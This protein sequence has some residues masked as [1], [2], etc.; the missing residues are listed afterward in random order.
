M[1]PYSLAI[2]TLGN[3][4][5]GNVENNNVQ[6][7]KPGFWGEY[8]GGETPANAGN[9]VPDNT[10]FVAPL[11]ITIDYLGSIYISDNF[12]STITKIGPS[13]IVTTL[14]GGGNAGQNG[15]G[16]AAGFN[17]P[18]GLGTDLEG[19]VYVADFDDEEIRKISSS[20]SGNNFSRQQF[21]RSYNGTGT[22]PLLMGLWV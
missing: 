21:H 14:A 9:G 19:N 6:L 18:I 12:F 15:I 10:V 20:R 7:I 16:V 2:D 11:G 13:G 17:G 4:Y 8:F 5:V 1:Q 3:I 22:L